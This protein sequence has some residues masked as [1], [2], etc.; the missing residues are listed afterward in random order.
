MLRWLLAIFLLASLAA[1][2]DE[3]SAVITGVITSNGRPAARVPVKSDEGF[4]TTTNDRGEYRLIVTPGHRWVSSGT[5]HADV[6]VAAGDTTRAD[7][8]ADVIREMFFFEPRDDREHA[9]AE[10]SL[11][12]Q[13]LLRLPIGRTLDD[14]TRIA[15]GARGTNFGRSIL[16]SATGG[17]SA[18]IDG[19]ETPG[20]P[21]VQLPLEFYD[22]VNILTIG[23]RLE[24]GHATGGLLLA[25]TPARSR[26]RTTAFLYYQPRQSS[27]SGVFTT[28]TRHWDAGFTTSVPF[29]DRLWLFAGYDHFA[30]DE[31]HSGLGV[32]RDRSTVDAMLAKLEFTAT[33]S[34]KLIAEGF[35][36]PGRTGF[37]EGSFHTGSESGLLRAIANNSTWLA[38]GGASHSSLRGS[39]FRFSH[40]TWVNANVERMFAHH[41]LRGGVEYAREPVYDFTFI[42]S[43]EDSRYSAAYL[44]DSWYA[45]ENLVVEGGIRHQ[46][47]QGIGDTWLPRASVIW[48]QS[49][50]LKLFATY[51][52]YGD[53]LA[54]AAP[55]SSPVTMREASAGAELTMFFPLS[56][57]L[58]HREI[59]GRSL[60]GAL[61][62]VA[63]DIAALRIHLADLIVSHDDGYANVFSDFPERRHQ[64]SLTAS[65]PIGIAEAGVIVTRP[66]QF[67]ADLHLGLRLNKV[68]LVADVMNVTGRDGD[69][70][71]RFGIRAA[72]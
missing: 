33:P 57:R 68:T 50:D 25:T 69:R 19:V 20:L 67:V 24:F 28:A 21:N 55:F 30:G 65:L 59:E 4:V 66:D 39:D 58:V 45:K 72:L 44:G 35:G 54:L 40:T 13:D 43:S 26:A 8:H 22:T 10:V 23:Q 38:E 32:F 1:R 48:R 49:R 53:D 14:V 12:Q 37:D 2:A 46:D 27:T 71:A 3:A 47:L 36:D 60:N 31:E 52:R 62:E 61:V 63:G 70:I 17:N 5:D 9:M 16:G 7:L 6:Y 29:T 18:F 51:G 11:Q 42:G 15:P 56:V 34:M 41:V 64:A